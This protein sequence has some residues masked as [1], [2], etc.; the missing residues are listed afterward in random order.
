MAPRH[1]APAAPPPTRG[2]VRLEQHGRNRRGGNVER[3]TYPEE[4]VLGGGEGTYEAKAPREE[5]QQQQPEA[6]AQQAFG[7]AGDMSSMFNNMNTDYAAKSE[8]NWAS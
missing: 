3:P 1:L 8:V 2:L 4:H 5:L 6:S 7:G